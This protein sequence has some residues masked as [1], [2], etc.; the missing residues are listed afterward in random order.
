L[1]SLG[2]HSPHL[3]FAL[4]QN[5]IDEANCA[6]R[7]WQLYFPA[8]GWAS[9]RR[10]PKETTAPNQMLNYGY[11]V[12]SALCHRSL[13]IHG[14]LPTLGVNHVARYRST[15]LV[16]DLMEPFR[17]LV[18]R[19]LADFRKEPDI[20]MRAWSKK[21]GTQLREWRFTHQRYSV[22]LMDAIDITVTALARAYRE[23]NVSP[24][25]VPELQPTTR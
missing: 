25:W 8:I 17:P 19:M 5:K 1:E 12:L 16:F 20:S 6:R 4:K 11:A 3:D 24:L 7:Y 23:Q 9:L 14:L 15:P 2:L 13:L 21:V 18:D 10:D 22:K